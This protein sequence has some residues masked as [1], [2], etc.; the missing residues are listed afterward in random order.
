M[1]HGVE[2]EFAGSEGSPLD[3]GYVRHQTATIDGVP[4][5]HLTRTSG[6]GTKRPTYHMETPTGRVICTGKEFVP[7][8]AIL[9][10]FLGV[11]V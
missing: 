7:A 11:N 5:A 6:A 9:Y 4:V 8:F 3:P 10:R 2:F 1:R